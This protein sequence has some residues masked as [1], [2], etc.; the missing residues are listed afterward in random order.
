[1]AP[2]FPG[3]T[4]VTDRIF[5]RNA[6]PDD[7]A[8]A[9]AARPRSASGK[10]PT[11]VL[12]YGWGDA[13]PKHV[14]KYADGYHALF[15]LARIVVVVSPIL[16]ASTQ[17]LGPRTRAMMPV[18]D[19][20]F[21]TAAAGAEE[22]V[23]LHVMSNTGGI[24]AA[25]TL[26]AYRQRH[27]AA[28]AAALPH[29]LCVSDSTPG[30]LVFRVE[31]WRWARA[32]ALAAPRWLPAR[33]ARRLCWA[34]LWLMHL[35]ARALRV[36][37]AGPY[38]CRVFLDPAVATTRAPRLYLYSRE[39]DL[40]GWRDVEAQAAEA[41]ARGYETVLERFEGSPHVGHMRVH[42][43]QY[44]AAILRCWDMSMEREKA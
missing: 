13:L 18:V 33:W 35:L 20:C 7:A 38:S 37:E 19:T 29:H 16:K 31:A 2:A 34:F 23:L 44:W 1:M 17:T 12:I 36:E 21:P 6:S 8:G 28:A 39:D 5:I 26:N 40:I 41:R 42:P 14:A 22:R 25:A 43:Q 11:L 27:G 32:M 15:P 24:Y 4:P 9:D 30:G 3:Y 10:D